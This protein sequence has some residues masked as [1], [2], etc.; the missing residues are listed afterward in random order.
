VINSWGLVVMTVMK[1]SLDKS[2]AERKQH[3]LLPEQLGDKGK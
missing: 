1:D 3:Q 2:F